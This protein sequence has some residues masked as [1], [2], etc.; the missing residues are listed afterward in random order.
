[1]RL[2]KSAGNFNRMMEKFS[3][4]ISQVLNSTHQLTQESSQ[5]EA[6]TEANMEGARR[7]QTETD[8]V[9]TAFTEMEQTSHEVASNATPGGRAGGRNQSAGHRRSGQSP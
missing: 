2:V 5:L 6:A 4:I 7:Q 1:M 3:N 8:Q 9:A